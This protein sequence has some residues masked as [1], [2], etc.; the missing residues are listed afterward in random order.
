MSPPH[1]YAFAVTLSTASDISDALYTDFIRICKKAKYYA[2]VCELDSNGVKHAHA[3][4][5]YSMAR[6]SDNVYSGTFAACKTFVDLVN[7]C[8]G[9]IKHAVKVKE[10]QSDAWIANYMQKDAPID[11]HNLPDD[12]EEL[13]FFFPDTAVKR[14]AN[15]EFE[16]WERMYTNEK[17]PPYAS[18]E[19]VRAFFDDHFY[20]TRDLKVCDDPR[21]L[22]NRINA[23]V[24]FINGSHE[25]LD[26]EDIARMNGVC[27]CGTP[28]GIDHI[29]PAAD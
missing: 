25:S 18:K 3:G 15:P 28:L 7:D 22:T 27:I 23:L 10:M 21:R 5:L 2:I 24:N 16:R 1:R 9:Q 19:S 20:R 14:T 4:L 26:S 11:L 12:F 13:R 17:R 6:R 29:C 8:G